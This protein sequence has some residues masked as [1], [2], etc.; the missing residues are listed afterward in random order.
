MWHLEGPISS[1]ASR[2]FSMN[3]SSMACVRSFR[4]AHVI[5]LGY[6]QAG[7]SISLPIVRGHTV[8]F[9]IHYFPGF[10]LQ[11]CLFFV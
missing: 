7:K 5:V 3:A 6:W 11:I 4:H 10:S 2:S 1:T 9:S 8:S